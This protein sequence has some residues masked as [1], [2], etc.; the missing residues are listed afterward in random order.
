MWSSRSTCRRTWFMTKWTRLTTPWPTRFGTTSP[1]ETRSSQPDPQGAISAGSS[2]TRS[3]RRSTWTFRSFRRKALTGINRPDCRPRSFRQRM[4]SARCGRS[5]NSMATAGRLRRPGIGGRGHNDPAGLKTMTPVNCV[6][7]LPGLITG[8]P[9]ST[10]ASA[11][12]EAEHAGRV[13]A[14]GRRSTA[15]AL[16]AVPPDRPH[17]PAA[18]ARRW[19]PSSQHR[20]RRRSGR[21]RPALHQAGRQATAPRRCGRR[22]SSPTC[23]RRPSSRCRDPDV[24]GG[25]EHQGDPAQVLDARKLAAAIPRRPL[26]LPGTLGL[27]GDH[28]GHCTS[29][30]KSSRCHKTPGR[31]ESD[32]G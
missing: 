13:C 28:S 10:P 18:G 25:S 8:S 31:R 11:A 2:P 16:S 9:A 7:Q 14:G 1:L 27:A 32:L 5:R 3:R 29:G 21:S 12:V 23:P 17:R 6:V 19:R 15:R 26:G 20:V 30:R 24:G 4:A 22:E